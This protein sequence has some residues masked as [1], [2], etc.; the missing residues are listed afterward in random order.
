MGNLQKIFDIVYNGLKSQCFQQSGGICG[1]DCMYRYHGKKCAAG[2]LIDDEYYSPE[3][4]NNNS[5]SQKVASAIERSLNKLG[6]VYD[7]QVEQMI[8]RLQTA[9]DLFEGS[10][11]ETQ[12]IKTGKEFGVECPG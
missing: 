12:I 2:W 3:L 6:L 1:V 8:R 5:N 10:A 9:H 11:M 7:A 4:E